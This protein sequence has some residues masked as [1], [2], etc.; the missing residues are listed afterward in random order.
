MATAL[1]LK[2][3][4]DYTS[5]QKA[6]ID[7]IRQ[8]FTALDNKFATVVGRIKEVRRS[9]DANKGVF[10]EADIQE[11]LA[12]YNGLVSSLSAA[13]SV[14]KQFDENGNIIEP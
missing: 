2:Q 11:M 5:N 7:F 3:R 13:L 8:Q 14:F 9:I 4:L 12:Y 6:D 1:E 10:E